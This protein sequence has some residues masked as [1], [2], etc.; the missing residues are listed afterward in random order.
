M[1][2]KRK[3]HSSRFASDD[4]LERMHECPTCF[5]LLTETAFESA[6]HDYPCPRCGQKKLSDFSTRE[7][8]CS[9]AKLCGG[10]YAPTE[11]TPC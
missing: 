3:P 2:A 10:A 1:K 8:V 7:W 11:R 6:R 9:N 4:G 5:Y